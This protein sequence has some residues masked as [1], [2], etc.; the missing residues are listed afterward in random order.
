MS[1][2]LK[3]SKVSFSSGITEIRHSFIF[4][5]LC[6]EPP[7]PLSIATAIALA[8]AIVKCRSFVVA[9]AER[10]KY[11]QSIRDRSSPYDN[12][13]STDRAPF[14]G[15]TN[16]RAIPVASLH[17]R[18]CNGRLYKCCRFFKS[19][20]NFIRAWKHFLAAIASNGWIL[21]TQTH[22]NSNR[23]KLLMP[24]IIPLHTVQLNIICIVC[25]RVQAKKK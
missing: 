1:R 21:S 10:E 2:R 7:L 4:Y 3:E 11:F 25:E 14:C 22:Q 16:T 18:L 5:F 9:I 20:L 23:I 19:H 15:P 24:M 13:H 8:M 6:H 17:V 12:Q